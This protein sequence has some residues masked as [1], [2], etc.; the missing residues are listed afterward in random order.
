[1]LIPTFFRRTTHESPSKRWKMLLSC[2]NGEASASSRP[3]TLDGGLPRSAGLGRAQVLTT[4]EGEP[5]QLQLRLQ[6]TELRAGPPDGGCPRVPARA[7][8]PSSY[9]VLTT[10]G[11]EGTAAGLTRT[12]VHSPRWSKTA[13]N[14]VRKTPVLKYQREIPKRMKK[15]INDYS[16]TRTWVS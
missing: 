16:A 1:M 10:E 5:R 14:A 6:H 7:Q 3:G 15:E 2:A 13:Q 4:E 12:N 11:G 9:P 8:P